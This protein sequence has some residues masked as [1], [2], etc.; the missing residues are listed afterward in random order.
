[1]TLNI[2]NLINYFKKKDL[3]TIIF[4]GALSQAFTSAEDKDIIF[5]K[6]F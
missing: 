3:H 5:G 2:N 1:M 6:K 4:S